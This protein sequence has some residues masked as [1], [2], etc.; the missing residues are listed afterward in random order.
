MNG[1][2]FCAHGVGEHLSRS[3]HRGMG[4]SADRLGAEIEQFQQPVF[5]PDL[6]ASQ[7]DAFVERQAQAHLIE[8]PD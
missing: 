6:F 5:R 3:A 1:V 4:R 8:H 7:K 2:G